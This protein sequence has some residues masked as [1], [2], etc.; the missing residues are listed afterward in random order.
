LEVTFTAGTGAVV[1][2]PL[3]TRSISAWTGGPAITPL[4][5][6]ANLTA[7]QIITIRTS[8]TG[9]APISGRTIY[10]LIARVQ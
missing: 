1:G 8:T 2:S 3:A 4:Q 6:R 5:I 9:L 10:Y 7:G